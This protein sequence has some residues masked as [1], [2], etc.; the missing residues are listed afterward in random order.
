MLTLA[1]SCMTAGIIFV[2]YANFKFQSYSVSSDLNSFKKIGSTFSFAKIVCDYW[3]PKL[4]FL[5]S[6]GVLS[7]LRNANLRMVTGNI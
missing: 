7:C 5:I 2:S 4:N 3:L 1:E 6:P